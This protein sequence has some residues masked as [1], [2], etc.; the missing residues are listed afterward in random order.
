[1]HW[2]KSICA[3]LVACLWLLGPILPQLH[4]L[5]VQHSVCDEHGE[6]VEG[7]G[8]AEEHTGHTHDESRT[9]SV[10]GDAPSDTHDHGCSFLA[11]QLSPSQ[12]STTQLDVSPMVDSPPPLPLQSR[13]IQ[14]PTLDFAPK[15]SPPKA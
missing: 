8:P 14:A 12:S 2:P 11:S 7:E 5:L 15:T 3:L 13:A 1:M 9:I 10:A 4:F 6:L